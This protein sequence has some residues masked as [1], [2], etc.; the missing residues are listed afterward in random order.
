[1]TEHR[2]QETRPDY[3][4]PIGEQ[5][6]SPGRNR[7]KEVVHEEVHHRPPFEILAE[8]DKIEKEIQTG[9]KELRGMLK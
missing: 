8:L 3:P 6:D 2:L 4:K 5:F 7:Y 9:L 1:M